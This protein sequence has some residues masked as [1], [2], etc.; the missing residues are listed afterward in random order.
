MARAV[1]LVAL[2][3]VVSALQSPLSP[4]LVKDATPSQI[5]LEIKSSEELPTNLDGLI[6]MVNQIEER[7]KA[8]QEADLARNDNR[9]AQCAADLLSLNQR[10]NN[11]ILAI[12]AQQ[13]LI[14][15]TSN[16]IGRLERAITIMDGRIIQD[17]K[18]L[19]IQ[20]QH[21]TNGQ[22]ERDQL[23]SIFRARDEDTDAADSAIKEILDLGWDLLVRDQDTEK[24]SSYDPTKAWNATL[25]QL[26]SAARRART[27]MA[28]SLLEVAAATASGLTRGDVD[29]L[30]KLLTELQAELARYKADLA[31]AETQ[32]KSEWFA[33]WDSAAQTGGEKATFQNEI[34]DIE[35]RLIADIAERFRLVQRKG[36]AEGAIVVYQEMW[37]GLKEQVNTGADA[38][39]HPG[40]LQ[41]L[42]KATEDECSNWEAHY[43]ARRDRRTEELR[44]IG[45]IYNVISQKTGTYQQDTEKF[46]QGMDQAADYTYEKT[47]DTVLTTLPPSEAESK[48]GADVRN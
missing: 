17:K 19:A 10:K 16:Q 46:E 22:Q 36:D 28:K 42:L 26:H 21:L 47:A 37:S 23:A 4:A 12:D 39:E 29:Q 33:P 24:A 38:E 45:E 43:N 40:A 5:L 2:V 13:G 3:A 18:D 30:K 41:T 1:L 48:F 14:A 35:A 11:T 15:E 27:P 8:A 20:R 6:Q 32:D 34:A 25:A 7:I 31:A 44:V 9:E